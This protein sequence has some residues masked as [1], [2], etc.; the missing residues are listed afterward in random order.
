M[1]NF[2]T[3]IGIGL[4]IANS[5]ALLMITSIKI[6]AINYIIGLSLIIVGQ[7]INKTTNKPKS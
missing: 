4:I 6:L 5:L 2:I 3:K 1:S 7:I